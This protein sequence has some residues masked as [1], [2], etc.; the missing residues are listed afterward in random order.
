MFSGR[1]TE[2]SRNI[3]ISKV[4]VEV[5]QETHTIK[6]DY[7]S[8]LT[9]LYLIISNILGKYRHGIFRNLLL[10]FWNLTYQTRHN[11]LWSAYEFWPFRETNLYC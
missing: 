7:N 9:R 8:N 2:I 3:D 6:P 5:M 4:V 11:R 1:N 10:S